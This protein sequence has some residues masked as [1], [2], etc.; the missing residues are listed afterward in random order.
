[1]ICHDGV[2]FVLMT[3]FILFIQ[4]VCPCPSESEGEQCISEKLLSDLGGREAQALGTGAAAQ[5]HRDRAICVG[6]C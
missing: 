3:M 1:M 5:L 2:P 4:L 6:G